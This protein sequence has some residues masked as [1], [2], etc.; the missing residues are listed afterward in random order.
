[1]SAQEAR[2][3]APMR[4]RKG[5]QDGEPGACGQWAKALGYPESVMIR[6]AL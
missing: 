5:A 3:L 1:M 2:H 6:L 4:R